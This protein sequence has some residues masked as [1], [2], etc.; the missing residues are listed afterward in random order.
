[1]TSSKI[2]KTFITLV[3]GD[4]TLEDSNKVG[5]YGFKDILKQFK[6][7]EIKEAQK[8][9]RQ[10]ILNQLRTI[11]LENELVGMRMKHKKQLMVYFNAFFKQFVD[12]ELEKRMAKCTKLLKN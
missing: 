10:Q 7:A 6:G 8:N 11:N 12:G 4:F 5:Q 1:M 9:I 2:N 3:F